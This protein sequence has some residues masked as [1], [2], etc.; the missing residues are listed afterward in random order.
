MVAAGKALWLGMVGELGVMG[1]VEADPLYHH[2]VA[3]TNPFPPLLLTPAVCEERVWPQAHVQIWV[4][5]IGLLPTV[6]KVKLLCAFFVVFSESLLNS[7][8][9]QT[10]VSLLQLDVKTVLCVA[11]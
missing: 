1:R 3:E 7:V 4:L 5:V 10:H 2:H 6:A 11:F 9:V 8:L